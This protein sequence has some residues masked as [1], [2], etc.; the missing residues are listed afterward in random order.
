MWQ[1]LGVIFGA[2]VS[3]GAVIVVE[4]LRMPSLYLKHE[5]PNDVEYPAG[6]FPATHVRSLRVRLHNKMLPS[7]VKWMVRGPAVQCR[8]RITF[9]FLTDEKD[10]FGRAMAGRWSNT[11]QPI[12]PFP[13][14]EG[15][16]SPARRNP[17]TPVPTLPPST[18]TGV[19]VVIIPGMAEGVDVYPGESDLLDI[20]I[21]ADGETACYGWDNESFALNWRNLRW[22]LERGRHL[23]RVEVTSSGRRCIAWF[24]LENAT[25]RGDFRLE[26]YSPKHPS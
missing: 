2:L 9:R 10:M 7:W 12:M 20:A 11:P 21:R 19:Q 14:N 4:Y 25:E 16:Q 5:P 22:K 1:F 15:Q 8:A 24:C 26:P 18:P 13:T 23:V 6:K 17:P 3:I